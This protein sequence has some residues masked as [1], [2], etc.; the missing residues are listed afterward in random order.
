VCQFSGHTTVSLDGDDRYYSHHQR[1][2]I[3]CC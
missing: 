3:Y 1:Q 2:N